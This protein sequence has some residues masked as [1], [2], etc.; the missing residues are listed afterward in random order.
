M[1]GIR[2]DAGGRVLCYGNPAGY[3]NGDRA[4][5]DPLFQTDELSE[6]LEKQRFKVIWRNGTYDRL[7]LGDGSEARS[8][9]LKGCRIWQLRPGTPFGLR[10]IP[11]ADSLARFGTPCLSNYAAVY[12]GQVETNELEALFEKFS[13][14]EPPPG[15]SGYPLSMSDLVELYDEGGSIFYYCDRFGFQALEPWQN[16]QSD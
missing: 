5:V 2:I 1:T 3:V 15:Y 14:V 10:F 13:A 11:Y 9:P 8:S 7:F 4:V 6:F 12:N 16:N